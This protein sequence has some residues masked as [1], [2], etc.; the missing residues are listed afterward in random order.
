[1]NRTLRDLVLLC[2]A[3]A[4]VGCQLHGIQA[5]EPVTLIETPEPLATEW[6]TSTPAQQGM[7]GE[8]M[9][10]L[11]GKLASNAPA[12]RSVLV[13]RR[14]Y[15]VFEHYAPGAGSNDLERIT[16]EFIIPATVPASN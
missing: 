10:Q 13:V 2:T 3:V 16:R 12:I 6:P 1:M 15:L 8:L 11:S 9:A 7:N 14:G 4:L 5:S